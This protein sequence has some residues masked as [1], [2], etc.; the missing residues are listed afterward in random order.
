MLLCVYKESSVFCY[1]EKWSIDTA[2]LPI[3]FSIKVLVF[4]HIFLFYM[5]IFFN[6]APLL[7]VFWITISLGFEK[8]HA[9]ILVIGTHKR[10]SVVLVGIFLHYVWQPLI[11]DDIMIP[12]L[13]VFSIIFH[14]FIFLVKTFFPLESVSSKY[15][16]KLVFTY[17]ILPTS[18]FS[19][20]LLSKNVH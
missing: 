8:D 2:L 20:F 5:S 9:L 10:F 14:N 13:Q 1:I 15:I 17:W 6:E 18:F 12:F 3:F 16:C 11:Q 4:S 7:E 19:Y